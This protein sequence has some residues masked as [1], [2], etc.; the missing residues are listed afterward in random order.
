[1]IKVPEPGNDF[2]TELVVVIY[3]EE[4]TNIFAH[5]ELLIHKNICGT[6]K[7]LIHERHRQSR[8]KQDKSTTLSFPLNSGIWMFARTHH[9]TSQTQP[10]LRLGRFVNFVP[11]SPPQS[12]YQ[13][14]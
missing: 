13:S 12:R 3:Q 4:Q 6:G 14:L 5:M 1:M 2:C 7:I 11:I 9:T 8:N 10:A